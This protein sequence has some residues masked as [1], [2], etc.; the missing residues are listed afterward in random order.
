MQSPAPAHPL[1]IGAAAMAAFSAGS[2][3]LL[4]ALTCCQSWDAN[5][6]CLKDYFP[7][8]APAHGLEKS[9]SANMSFDPLG[10]KFSPLQNKSTS[11]EIPILR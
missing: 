1:E 5:G 6:S 8:L 7:V 10:S 9:Y 4:P 11:G 2:I 3:S